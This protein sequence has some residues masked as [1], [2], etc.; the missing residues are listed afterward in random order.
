MTTKAVCLVVKLPRER[1]A[2]LVENGEGDPFAPAGKVFREWVSIPTVGREL[3]Q[4]L[5][6]E[7]TDFARGGPTG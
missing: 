2:K 3:W 6:A 1:V 7:A 4:T 5:L